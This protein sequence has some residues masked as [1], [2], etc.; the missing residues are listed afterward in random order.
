MPK[1]RLDAIEI[2]QFWSKIF[3]SSKIVCIDVGYNTLHNL[4]IFNDEELHVAIDQLKA[5][6]ASDRAG[7]VAEMIKYG[8]AQLYEHILKFFNEI[9]IKHQM[10]DEWLT[11]FFTLIPKSGCLKQVANWRPIAVMQIMNKIFS[12][13]LFNRLKKKISMRLSC[14]QC[15]YRSNFCVEDC[16]FYVDTLLSKT[17]EFGMHVWGAS[18]DMQKAFD[19]IEH[20]AIFDALRFFE[21]DEGYLALIYIM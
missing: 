14:D 17:S 18:L 4:L 11:V 1:N 20:H 3:K 12:R 2:H 6:K 13:M 9:I 10:I 7:I 15:A 21:I 8:S 5:R 19:R 16:L